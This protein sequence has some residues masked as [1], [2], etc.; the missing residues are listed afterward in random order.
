MKEACRCTGTE[1]E[2]S[3]TCH[4]HVRATICTVRIALAENNLHLRPHDDAGLSQFR[5][6]FSSAADLWF[7]LEA[8]AGAHTGPG[9]IAFDHFKNLE[10]L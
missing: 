10:T 6:A 5:L 7:Q 9:S 2:A 4:K 8:T 1:L 3:A